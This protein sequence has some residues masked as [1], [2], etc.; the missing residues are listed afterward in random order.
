MEHIQGANAALALLQ[1][2][3]PFAAALGS[4]S[5][6]GPNQAI[7]LSWP[8]HMEAQDLYPVTSSTYTLPTGRKVAV[9]CAAQ[10]KV[11][12]IRQTECPD[13]FVNPMNPAHASPC[14]KVWC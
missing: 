1:G 4:G 12:G 9:S 14:V 8:Q 3:M 10:G 6:L 11:V 5:G 13:S 2:Q 7:S